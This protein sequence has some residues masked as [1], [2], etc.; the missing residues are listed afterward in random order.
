MMRI[1]AMSRRFPSDYKRLWYIVRKDDTCYMVRI[2]G[3]TVQLCFTD[4]HMILDLVL[5]VT[6]H[7]ENETEPEKVLYDLDPVAGHPN[8]YKIRFK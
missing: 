6:R 7:T 8:L 4:Y 2:R 1:A 5:M 3:K